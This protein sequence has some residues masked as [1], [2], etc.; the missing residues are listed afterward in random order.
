MRFSDDAVNDPATDA[1]IHWFVPRATQRGGDIVASEAG[2]DPVHCFVVEKFED[3]TAQVLPLLSK[4]SSF[5]SFVRQLND[6]CCS[7]ASAYASCFPLL[8][9]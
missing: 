3:F 5:C 8:P 1:I 7:L 6:T 4:S 9:T 2:T